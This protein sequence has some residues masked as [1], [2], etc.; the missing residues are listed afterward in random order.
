[1][2]SRRNSG[3]FTLVEVLVVVSIIAMVLSF[4]IPTIQR[5]T[6]YQLNAT[7]RK[8]SG[9]LKTVRDRAVFRNKIH[10][11]VVSFEDQKYWIESQQQLSPIDLA[12]LEEAR[13][14]SLGQSKAEMP[15]TGFTLEPRFGKEPTEIPDGLVLD[16]V[17][18]AR[19]GLLQE[20]IAYIHF[21]P[22]GY[23]DEAIIFLRKRGG[24]GSGY[25]LKLNPVTGRAEIA[26]ESSEEYRN[27]K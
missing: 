2:I 8:F 21:F 27:R 24:Q 3:G 13:K 7:T 17:Y 6:N 12:Q 25:A 5:V 14:V 20:G 16:G 18:T 9:L 19:D 11:L 4:G 22:N 10:R 1:M 26:S 23:N 15:D